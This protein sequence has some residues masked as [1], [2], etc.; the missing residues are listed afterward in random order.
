MNKIQSKD[1][2]IGTYEIKKISLT[3]F[4]DKIYIKIMGM[5]DQL[6][7]TRVNHRKK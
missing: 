2:E 4:D 7:D 6:L 3:G 1:H 5:I